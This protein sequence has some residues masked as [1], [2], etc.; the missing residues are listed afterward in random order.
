MEFP[1]DA[2]TRQPALTAAATAL[3][4]DGSSDGLPRLRLMIGARDGAV[5]SEPPAPSAGMPAAY[6]TPCAT[7]KAMPS[8]VMPRTRIGR[9]RT[10]Q[11]TPVTG[12]LL[13]PAAPMIPEVHCPWSPSGLCDQQV[14]RLSSITSSGSVASGCGPPLPSMVVNWTPLEQ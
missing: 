11:F 9:M 10:A 14:P 7:S 3:D 5:T 2:T 13:L 6:S 4:S 1:A 8:P 12:P